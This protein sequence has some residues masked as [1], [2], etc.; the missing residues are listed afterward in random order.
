MLIHHRVHVADLQYAEPGFAE[1]LADLVKRH[2]LERGALG[3]EVTEETLARDV[4]E[5]AATLENLRDAGLALAVD[6]FGSWYSSLAT[7]GDLPVDAVKLDPSFVRGV[8][9]DL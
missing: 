2:G 3:I 4:D 8:G 6:D 1:R 9:S 7:L 5:V